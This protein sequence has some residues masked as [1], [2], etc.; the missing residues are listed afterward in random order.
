MLVRL[1]MYQRPHRR[2]TQMIVIVT[3]AK[4]RGRDFSQQIHSS[5][6]VKINFTWEVCAGEL[7]ILKLTTFLHIETIFPLLI[8]LNPFRCRSITEISP[9]QRSNVPTHYVLH[10]AENSLPRLAILDIVFHLNGH[11]KIYVQQLESVLHLHRIKLGLPLK[12]Y[13]KFLVLVYL[14]FYL[15]NQ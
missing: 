10:A 7:S 9:F 5:S 12:H 3:D 11:W 4:F 2:S 15:A 14:V 6:K 13:S 1:R 8:Y